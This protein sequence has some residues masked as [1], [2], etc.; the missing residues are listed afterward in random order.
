MSGPRPS[1]STGFVLVGVVMM[2][3]ALTIIGLSLYSLSGYETQ[4]FGRSLFERQALYSGSSGI[5]LVKQLLLSDQGSP[6][7][8]RLSSA[9]LAV[10]R[11]GVVSAIAWQVSPPDT[12]GEVDWGQDVFIR[13]GVNVNG[14]TRTIEGRFTAVDRDNPYHY[15]LTVPGILRYGDPGDVLTGR[16]PVRMRTRAGGAWQ[17]IP[18]GDTLWK[19]EVEFP[20]GPVPVVVGNAPV[21]SSAQFITDHLGGATAATMTLAGGSI[22]YNTITL[23]AG[24]GSGFFTSPAS[25]PVASLA[26]RN[27]WDFVSQR[28]LRVRVRGTAVWLVPAGIRFSGGVTF[29]RLNPFNDANLVIVSGPNGRYAGEQDVGVHFFNGIEINPDFDERVNVFVVTHGSMKDKEDGGASDHN[30]ANSL[31]IFAQNYTMLPGTPQGSNYMYRRYRSTMTAVADDLLGR[32]LLPQPVGGTAK[33]LDLVAG[34]WTTS[35]GLP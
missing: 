3:I 19:D 5:E 15:L 1:G 17:N 24:S 25:D 10:G 8:P 30:K 33:S 35:P 7:V 6:A 29:E 14:V 21:P 16:A 31:C 34:S 12:T 20:E 27:G 18:P 32:G 11:E 9:A 28:N 26:E 22:V 13:V 23:D 2:V 4:F